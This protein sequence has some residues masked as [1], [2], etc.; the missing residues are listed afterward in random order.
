MV[1]LMERIKEVAKEFNT[2]EWNIIE[3]CICPVCKKGLIKHTVMEFIRHSRRELD[4]N[5]PR[6]G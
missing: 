1:T 5:E 6:K 4:E 3:H 2:S